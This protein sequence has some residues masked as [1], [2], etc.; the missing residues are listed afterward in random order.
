MSG[1]APVPSRSFFQEDSEPSAIGI[2][3]EG[4][5]EARHHVPCIVQLVPAP[6]EEKT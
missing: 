1:D 5:I 3:V 2:A 4:P 6:H